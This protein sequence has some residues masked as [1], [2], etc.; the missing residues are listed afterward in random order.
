MQH[1]SEAGDAIRTVSGAVFGHVVLAASMPVVVEF[2]SYSCA[3]CRAVEAALQQVARSVAPQQLVCRVNVAQDPELAAQY[4][5]Q[6]TPTLVMF[7]DGEVV[8]RVEG[9]PPDVQSLLQAVAQ[10]FQRQP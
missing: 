10:A 5:V 2:M 6:G 9:P 4:S 3:H 1:N 7:S 8:A